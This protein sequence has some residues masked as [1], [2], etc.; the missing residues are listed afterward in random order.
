[1]VEAE[2]NECYLKAKADE[3]LLENRRNTP[4]DKILTR[5]A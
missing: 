5:V 1:M 3:A 4:H 2:R